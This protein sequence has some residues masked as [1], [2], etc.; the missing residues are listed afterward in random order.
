MATNAERFTFCRQCGE[1]QRGRKELRH[2]IALRHLP[3]TATRHPQSSVYEDDTKKTI[4][5]SGTT[6]EPKMP[7]YCDICEREFA[8]AGALQMHVQNS[9][10]HK[11]EARKQ[12]ISAQEKEV[13][14]TPQPSSDTLISNTGLYGQ[15][16]SIGNTPLTLPGLQFQIQNDSIATLYLSTHLQQPSAKASEHFGSAAAQ[17][18]QGNWGRFQHGHNHWSLIPAFQ[19]LSVFETLFRHCHL[20][21]DL[22]DNKYRLHMYNSDDIAGL[23]KCKNCGSKFQTYHLGV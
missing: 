17:D 10:I 20:P 15:L 4:H 13:K 5:A 8:H 14:T 18:S 16:P 6:S 12:R 23:R 2:H 22:L 3:P 1:K 11:K 9:K 7:S 21:E 19:Q